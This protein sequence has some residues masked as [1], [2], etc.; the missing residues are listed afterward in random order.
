MNDNVLYRSLPESA[1]TGVQW[2]KYRIQPHQEFMWAL[3]GGAEIILISVTEIKRQ[4]SHGEDNG[5][6]WSR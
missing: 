1:R 4:D 5:I 2:V 6:L 3:L